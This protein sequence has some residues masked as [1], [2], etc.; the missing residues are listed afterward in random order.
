MYRRRCVVQTRMYNAIVQTRHIH[1]TESY[2]RVCT[3]PYLFIHVCTFL[4]TR[5]Y[6]VHTWYIHLEV[7]TRLYMVQTCMYMYI[8]L[9]TRLDLYKH[10]CIMKKHVHTCLVHIS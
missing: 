10:V 6:I 2:R 4:D 5:L 9:Y 8:Q 1:G 7:S 3:F